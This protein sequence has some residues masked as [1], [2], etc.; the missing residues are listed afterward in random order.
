MILITIIYYLY[1]QNHTINAKKNTSIITNITK[2]KFTNQIKVKKTLK[3]PK[4]LP[5]TPEKLYAPT[6]KTPPKKNTHSK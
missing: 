4:C 5:K 3:T 2:Y 6:N 1:I